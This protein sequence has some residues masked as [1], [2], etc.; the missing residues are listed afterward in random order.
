MPMTAKNNR[1]R[2]RALPRSA[3]APS[4]GAIIMMSRLASELA[5]PSQKL[6]AVTDRSALQYCLKNSGKNP[7]ITT[8]AKAELA[9]S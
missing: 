9:Q 7:A 5:A 8:V 2:L 4:T 3:M 1:K 6:L